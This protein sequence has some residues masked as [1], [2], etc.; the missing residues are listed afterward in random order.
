MKQGF[1]KV[2]A[3]TPNVKVADVEYNTK[4]IVKLI[5]E[6]VS[7]GAKIIVFQG[8]TPLVVFP[9]FS[10]REKFTLFGRSMSA[11]PT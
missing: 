4:E 1:V 6:T 3:V 5:D 10:L 9:S 7:N 2:A 11:R 8:K